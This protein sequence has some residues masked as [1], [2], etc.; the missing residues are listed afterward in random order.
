MLWQQIQKPLCGERIRLLLLLPCMAPLAGALTWHL[1]PTHSIGGHDSGYVTKLA[2]NRVHNN[3]RHC[4]Q[5]LHL[6]QSRAYWTA[7]IWIIKL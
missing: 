3:A 6:V 7:V 1:Q 2:A 5:K 4:E